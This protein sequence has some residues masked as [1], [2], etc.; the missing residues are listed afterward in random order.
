MSII[1]GI[2]KFFDKDWTSGNSSTQ[3]SI[4]AGDGTEIAKCDRYG[5][6]QFRGIGASPKME[7]INVSGNVF[8]NF[9]TL[10]GNGYFDVCSSDGT[11][12]CHLD[13]IG[14]SKLL[15][16]DVQNQ[17]IIN[18]LDGEDVSDAVN[19]GQLKNNKS[20]FLGSV[21]SQASMLALTGNQ[22]DWCIRTDLTPNVRYDLTGTDSTDIDSWTA[23]PV[24]VEAP[25]LA[26]V[27]AVG[28]T[29]SDA[30]IVL[31]SE[32]TPAVT[33]I[34]DSG[35]SVASEVNGNSFGASEQILVEYTDDTRVTPLYVTQLSPNANQIRNIDANS[36]PI[37]N[38]STA[39]T[40]DQAVNRGQMNT[41]IAN[42]EVGILVDCGNYDPTTTSTYPIAG[43]TGTSG[44][45][46][47]GNVFYISVAGTILTQPVS[48]GD[49]LRALVNTPGVTPSNWDILPAISDLSGKVDKNGTDS[50]MSATEHSKLSGIAAGATVGDS[51]AIHKSVAGEIDS[52]TAK[53][54]I[55]DADEAVIEDSATTPTTFGK[56]KVSFLSIWNYIKSK[57]YGLTGNN[58]SSGTTLFTL[59]ATS[60]RKRWAFG[61]GTANY[62]L[63]NFASSYEGLEFDFINDT[64]NSSII[65][66][67]DGTTILMTI[68]SGMR[69]KVVFINYGAD[70][71][72]WTY[73]IY[74]NVGTLATVAKSGS[75]ADLSTKAVGDGTTIT[76]DGTAGNPFVSSGGGGGGGS[77]T[78]SNL[79][80]FNNY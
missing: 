33:T 20:Q 66:S 48:V 14:I 9:N 11:I 21:T 54:L 55:V 13:S 2:I 26:E 64:S 36:T 50:L 29:A 10:Y 76:G 15:G 53:T 16:L 19:F 69:G 63:P 18:V 71:Y 59:T 32:H 46:L 39:T 74:N 78:G 17:K 23:N 45:I 25:T 80:L 27:L 28:N 37:S 1:R 79:Y 51:D 61:L 42:S 12:I 7:F 24:G 72:G 3:F 58:V 57:V 70:P 60:D 68:P 4:V 5:Q 41:A 35:V 6:W 62:K 43:G 77:N 56:K 65:Y 22:G 30:S 75:Y 67:E 8:A 73:T 38:V 31:N 44:A 49:T 52:L 40:D 47:K 34:N